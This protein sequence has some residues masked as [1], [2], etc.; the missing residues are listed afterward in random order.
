MFR[1]REIASARRSAALRMNSFKRRDFVLL[2][3][4][5]NNRGGNLAIVPLSQTLFRALRR[6]SS[7]QLIPFLA[8]VVSTAPL[9]IQSCGGR[10]PSF[11]GKKVVG[12]ALGIV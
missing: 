6:V 1:L 10:G 2:V 7:C 3:S 5:A 12:L 8:Q 4:A 9:V 11:G